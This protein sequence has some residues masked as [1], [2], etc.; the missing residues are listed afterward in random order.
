MGKGK[1]IDIGFRALDDDLGK[2]GLDYLFPVRKGVG[3]FGCM[4]NGMLLQV[5]EDARQEAKQAIF[6]PCFRQQST[7]SI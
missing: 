4:L 3:E 5:I 6:F 2:D 7:V 1:E